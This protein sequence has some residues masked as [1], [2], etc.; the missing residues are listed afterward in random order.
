MNRLKYF[1]KYQLLITIIGLAMLLVAVVLFIVMLFTATPT[2]DE[3]G[4][5]TTIEYNF[6]I[7]TVLMIFYLLHITAVVWFL[8]RSITYKLRIKEEDAL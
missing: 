3:S 1:D 6:T 5:L 2:Y 4:H 8:A 7:Q